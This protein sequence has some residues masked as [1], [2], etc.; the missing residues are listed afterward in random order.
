M[1][2][3]FRTLIALTMFLVG[4]SVHAGSL[5]PDSPMQ[6][7]TTE[8]S[9]DCFSVGDT[10]QRE[11]CFS[12]ESD[13]D[14]DACERVMPSACRPYKEMYRAEQRLQAS[15]AKLLALAQARDAPYA[16]DDP[17][18]LADL[19]HYAQAS[20]QAWRNYRDAQCL[21]EP[22][23]QG[24][25]RRESSNLTEA[26]RVKATKARLNALNSLISGLKED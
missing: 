15:N 4:T 1:T 20:D 19:A 2:S 9:K 7:S 13:E 6:D 11:A 10:K 25:S 26:C 23:M 14:I 5:L 18:Y 22:F 17:A 24:M 12:Q 21:L 16:K 3:S 8:Q